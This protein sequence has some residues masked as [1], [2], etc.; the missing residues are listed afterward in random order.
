MASIPTSDG[1]SQLTYSDIM[2][3]ARADREK[4][5]RMSENDRRRDK[6][7]KLQ[8]SLW[9]GYSDSNVAVAVRNLKV[10]ES[11]QYP[12]GNKDV[13]FSIKITAAIDNDDGSRS[14]WGRWDSRP[15]DPAFKLDARKISVD[16]R[17]KRGQSTTDHV[18]LPIYN[19]QEY[20]FTSMKTKRHFNTCKK[21][22]ESNLVKVSRQTGRHECFSCMT[23]IDSD[24]YRGR[25]CEHESPSGCASCIFRRISGT[26]LE[27]IKCFRCNTAMFG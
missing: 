23:V 9:D 14:F 8:A 22:A 17:G 1:D 16:V 21:V 2:R 10:G 4:K 25:R 24:S 26:K 3:A 13:L 11:A 20:D 19:T 15:R 5:R 7:H 18:P 6:R 12:H 27:Y